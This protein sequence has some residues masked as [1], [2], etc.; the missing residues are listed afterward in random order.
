MASVTPHPDSP[1][2]PAAPQRLVGRL[3]LTVTVS[4]LVF[5]FY[6][7]IVVVTVPRLVERELGR[8]EFGVGLTIASFAAAAVVV[9]P[10]LGRLIDRFGRRA[11]LVTGAMLS[12]VAAAAM[13]YSDA[14][15]QVIALRAVMGIGEAGLFVSSATLVADLAPPSRRA[16]AASY[17]SV[18]VYGGI[19]IGPLLGEWALGDD[20]YAAAF[21]LAGGL[22]ALAAV[23]GL[24]LPPRVERTS[25]PPGARPPLFHRAALW[26]GLVMAAGV[27]AFSVFSAFIPE[28]STAVG[29]SGAAGLFL[30]YSA[31]SVSLRFFGAKLPERLGERR[32]VSIALTSLG[33]SLG[34]LAAVA[35]PW[36][37]WVAAGG[38]GLGMAFMYPSL[39]ANV[40][41]R[42]DDD[43]RASA[44][45]SF[46]MFFE[47]GTVV[48]GV[49]LGAVG[50]LFDKRASFFGAALIALSGLWVLWNRV[51]PSEPEH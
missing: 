37:L 5:F 48:G 39:M 42:V 15:W 18:A 25:P 36:A 38:V 3:F 24:G 50:Q 51:V 41:N 8:G 13:G 35:E 2:R 28:H 26:P 32:M 10:L 34:L 45:S 14:L 49:G 7:G 44:L 12:A 27:G 23:I 46:T 22:A 33:A 6:I 40:V 47:L 11:I 19:G 21:W 20:R 16:E 30:V 43:E 17:F 31:V 9:R 29:M 1:A 4:A